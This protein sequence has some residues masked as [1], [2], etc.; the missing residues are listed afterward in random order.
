MRFFKGLVFLFFIAHITWASH[1][2]YCLINSCLVYKGITIA[3]F[4]MKHFC[5][6]RFYIFQYLA[7]AGCISE[8]L[9]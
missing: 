5:Y 6:A 9:F 8:M 7:T 3:N 4:Y 2:L 1:H